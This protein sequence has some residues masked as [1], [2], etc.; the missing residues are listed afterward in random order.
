MSCVNVCIPF[1][2]SVATSGLV[3]R[4]W[5]SSSSVSFYPSVF[6]STGQF[7]A[8]PVMEAKVVLSWANACF[9]AT[10]PSSVDAGASTLTFAGASTLTFA[11]EPTSTSNDESVSTSNDEPTATSNDESTPSFV[12]SWHCRYISAL[13]SGAFM[14]TPFPLKRFFPQDQ[15]QQLYACLKRFI[16]QCQGDPGREGQAAAYYF[17]MLFRRSDWPHCGELGTFIEVSFQLA[18]I[19]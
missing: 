5:S 11:D 12:A 8:V 14:L 17:A 4:A 9:T 1:A 19:D 10:F 2:R 16:L 15:H 6:A 13:W 18:L 7:L 3:R